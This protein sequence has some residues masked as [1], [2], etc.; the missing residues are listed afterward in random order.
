MNKLVILRIILLISI[1]ILLGA[2]VAISR[3]YQD[4]W[5]LEGLEIPFLLFLAAFALT[6]FLEKKESL[7]V[8]LAVLGRIVFLLIPNLKYA[9]FQG[10]AIDQYT[11]YNLAN[12]VVNTGR[13]ST[14]ALFTAYTVAPL[15]HLLLSIFSIVLNLPVVD[16]MKYVPVLFS[17]MYPL[18]T[19]AIVKKMGIAQKSNILKYALFLSSIPISQGAYTVTGTMFG[20]LLAFIILFLLVAILQKNDRRY[21]L[22]CVIFVIALALAHSLT[23]IILTGVLLLVLVIQRVPRFRPR[24]SL[25]TSA[26]L[27]VALISLAWLMFPAYSTFETIVHI[28]SVSVPSGVTPTS[29]YIPSTFFQLAQTEPSAAVVTFLVYYGADL[30]LLILTLVG[31]VIMFRMRKK[32]NDASSFLMFFW[33]L[34]FAIM[35]VGIFIKAGSTRALAFEELLFPIFCG[36]AIS[37]FSNKRKWISPLLFVSII[38]LATVELYGAQPLIPSATIIYPG[39]PASV[40]IGYVN[41]VTSVYQRQV[42]NFALSHVP[43]GAIASDAVTYNQIAGMAN[44]S[45]IISHMMYYYP[46]GTQPQEEYNLLIIHVPGKAGVL[47]EKANVRTPDLILQTIYNSSVVYT[48]GESFILA[49]TR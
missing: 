43:V 26:I 34:V 19:Y 18:L 17:P 12:Y 7:L 3:D 16:S 32:L 2:A 21:W 24:P 27:A 5:I 22:V 45:F 39:L 15:F 25:R 46:I 30:L 9:W 31:L 49:H 13:I 40:P 47:E 35:I 37:Y 23:S 11:Q 1:V 48:N 36:I 42:V 38:I 44:Y 33:V 20:I 6:F 28:L 10:V 41:E 14:N 4:G 8:G 29:E